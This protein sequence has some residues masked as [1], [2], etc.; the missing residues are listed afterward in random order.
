MRRLAAGMPRYNEMRLNIRTLRY[1]KIIYSELKENKEKRHT[2]ENTFFFW[3][4]KVIHWIFFPI[5][6]INIKQKMKNES[7]N[8]HSEKIKNVLNL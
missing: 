3:Q 7:D 4:T 6:L 2:A 1:I 5:T 8:G